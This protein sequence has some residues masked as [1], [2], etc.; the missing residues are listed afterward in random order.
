MVLKIPKLL[1]KAFYFCCMQGSKKTKNTASQILKMMAV[2]CDIQMRNKKTA[3]YYFFKTKANPVPWK[4]AFFDPIY[5]LRSVCSGV[6]LREPVIA[7][8]NVVYKVTIEFSFDFS[9]LCLLCYYIQYCFA[10]NITSRSYMEACGAYST[11]WFHN[12]CTDP[13]Q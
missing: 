12:E 2:F 3:A 9:F 13:F 7:F 10:R 6:R 11:E 8:C 1:T 5:S 4:I